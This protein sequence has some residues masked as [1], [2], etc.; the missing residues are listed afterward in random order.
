MKETVAR[1][2][3][4]GDNKDAGKHLS[5]ENSPQGIFNLIKKFENVTKSSKSNSSAV[6]TAKF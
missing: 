5:M 4:I 6:S 2:E 1:R 3:G